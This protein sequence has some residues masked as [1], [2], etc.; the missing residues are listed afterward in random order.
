M[1]NRKP[2]AIIS[3]LSIVM[4]TLSIYAVDVRE[5]RIENIGSGVIDRESVLAFTSI[6]EGEEF[7]RSAV[8]R[9][10]KALQKSGRFSYVGANA[11][12]IGEAINI[13]YIV[14]PKPVIKRIEISG[15][16]YLGNKKVR[17]KLELGVGDYV[18]DTTLAVKSQNV[19]QE[20]KKKYY[21]NAELTW[22]IDTDVDTGLAVVRIEVDEGKRAHVSKIK[23]TG[24]TD[25][26]SN[27]KLRK[28]MQQ[29][30]S[31]LLSFITGSGVYDPLSLESDLER[32]RLAYMN[33]G[34]LDVA[35]GTPLIESKGKRKIMI[36]L[37]IEQG[38]LYRVGT[39]TLS[40]V[41]LFPQEQVQGLIMLAPGS[42]ASL[43]A[44]EYSSQAIRDFYGSRGYIRTIVEYE[45]NADKDTGLADVAFAVTEGSLAYIRNI[46]I[47]GNTRTKDKVIRREL[48]VYPG[49]VYN[50]V[51]VR[52]SQ[53]RVRNLGYFSYVNTTPE[54]T[55]KEDEFDL[56]M[57]VEE[58]RTGQFVVG[59]G[60]S[61]VDNLVG[62]VEVSQGNFDLLGWPN[63]TGGGQKLKLRTQFGS[64]R[65]DYELSFVEPWFLNRRL[66]LGFD[67]Y[68]RES[69]FL[70]DEYDQANTGGSLTLGKA[71]SGFNR[72]NLT[73]GLERVKVDNV[74][75]NAS[76]LIQN[77]AGSRMKSYSQLELIHD[78]RNNVFIPSRGN[79]TTIAGTLAGGPLG[80]DTDLYGLQLRASQYYPLWWG[81]VFNLRGWAAMVNEYGDSQTV[82]IFDRLFLGGARTLR[83]FKYREV[84]PKEPGVPDSNGQLEGGG[85]PVGGKSA[86]YGTAEYTIPIVDKV[87]FAVFYDVGVIWADLF[88]KGNVSD[89][90]T[91]EAGQSDEFVGDGK[92]NSD[93]GIGLRLDMPGFPIQLDYSWQLENDEENERNSGRFSF[94]IGYVY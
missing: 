7:N 16:D 63:F 73:Y 43:T 45:L 14:E 19:L 33:E 18:D 41:T 75:S 69:R 82:P 40:G 46:Q 71:V 1:I 54:S 3:W 70:S 61:S 68:H 31:S 64:E 62:F 21:P 22:T 78:S 58:Q 85:E 81:H 44:I 56:V 59:A 24:D 5:I 55:V 35:V 38:P 6:R 23:F 74:S 80:A 15:A 49:D 67:L 27:Y 65:N 20:Y 57:D 89:Y 47:R 92:L 84:G 83:A 10:I 32:I 2:F 77:E 30:K 94:W 42:I 86:L 60:F 93:V 39:V 37:P 91:P 51:R 25:G 90:Y 72:V 50:E 36:T 87:R 88:S 12:T 52:K 28:L 4:L 79:R 53:N 17:K 8:S 48:T 26:I 9:D 11:E 13:I 76:E 66:S 29:K 34:Y